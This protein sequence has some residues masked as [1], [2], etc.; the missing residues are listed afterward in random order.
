MTDA[1]EERVARGAA[2][3]DGKFPQWEGKLDVDALDIKHINSCVLGQLYGGYYTGVR[4]L[5]INDSAELA[6]TQHGFWGAVSPYEEQAK[7]TAEYD[8]LLVAWVAV[9]K[10][11]I[12]MR[13][14]EAEVVIEEKKEKV[15]A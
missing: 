11:R 9:I 7:I 3:L 6:A 5:G 2:L 15:A 4:E 1:L 14:L 12:E 13:A 8:D 10:E